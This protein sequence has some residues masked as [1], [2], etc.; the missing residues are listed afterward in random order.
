MKNR[1]KKE[2]RRERNRDVCLIFWDTAS[3]LFTVAWLYNM[4]DDW[5]MSLCC[6]LRQFMYYLFFL[7]SL[8][9]PFPQPLCNVEYHSALFSHWKICFPMAKRGEA[10][11]CTVCGCVPGKSSNSNCS[12]IETVEN[13]PALQSQHEGGKEISSCKCAET[14]Y[15][16]SWDLSEIHLTTILWV[17]SIELKNKL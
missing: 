1:E 17:G 9:L 13:T 11:I 2:W 16:S 10:H 5:V 15:A 12:Q 4:G 8:L 6:E 14:E 7:I 3:T